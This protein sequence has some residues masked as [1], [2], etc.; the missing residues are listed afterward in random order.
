MNTLY[1]LR[2]WLSL[3]DAA[4]R[5]SLSF[6]ET[7]TYQNVLELVIE[8]RLALSWFPGRIKVKSVYKID[9]ETQFATHGD[10]LTDTWEQPPEYRESVGTI[11]TVDII[12]E[13]DLDDSGSQLHDWLRLLRNSTGN[14]CDDYQIFNP[15]GFYVYAK[16][17]AEVWRV[18]EYVGATS[19]G[20]VGVIKA[21][22]GFYRPRRLAPK[23]AELIIQRDHLEYLE[24]TVQA[25][26][27]RR[28]PRRALHPKPWVHN[29]EMSH[30][31]D[32]KRSPRRPAP[33]G[34]RKQTC[35]LLAR[36]S[37]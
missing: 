22:D 37:T 13:L 15:N 28:N 25:Q 30:R 8:G 3:E 31:K 33:Y 1:S 27:W 9:G 36:C 7:V 12:V 14:E 20:T 29:Q 5:L 34:P 19:D 35:E 18:M 24:R 6:G 32:Q 23:R 26:L 10:E 11:G 21:D 16:P 4:K 17:D 2:T